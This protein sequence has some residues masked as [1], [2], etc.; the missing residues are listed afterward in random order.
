LLENAIKIL[1]ILMHTQGMT[2]F[3]VTPVHIASFGNNKAVVLDA[4]DNRLVVRLMGY[5]EGQALAKAEGGL[6][7]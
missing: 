3:E 1:G 7:I 5:E 2:E 6:P 4:R